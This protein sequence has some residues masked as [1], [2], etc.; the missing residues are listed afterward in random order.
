MALDENVSLFFQFLQLCVNS[1]KLQ[2]CTT[3]YE[4]GILNE[5]SPLLNHVK[6]LLSQALFKP[7]QRL[8]RIRVVVCKCKEYRCQVCHHLKMGEFLS[9]FI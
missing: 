9:G 2:K 3:K 1:F 5:T 7:F 8:L 4:P 6:C